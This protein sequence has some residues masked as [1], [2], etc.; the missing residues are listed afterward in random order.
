MVDELGEN[1]LA[2]EQKGPK[3]ESGA[4]NKNRRQMFTFTPKNGIKQSMII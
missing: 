3:R 1:I 4:G 2:D